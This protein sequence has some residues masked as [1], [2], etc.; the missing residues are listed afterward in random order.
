MIQN[1]N[2]YDIYGYL[3]PGLV[4]LGLVWLPFGLLT[5]DK[6]P[7]EWTSAIVGIA[8]AYIVG[9]VL[10]T[11][12]SSAIRSKIKDSGGVL[13]YPSEVLLDT[14][15]D[16]FTGE[17]KTRLYE[18]IRSS[19]GIDVEGELLEPSDSLSRRRQEVFFLCR[20]EL[21]K[22][23]SVSY[24]E[25]FEGMYT[26]MR[27]I[28]AA[29]AAGSAYYLGWASGGLL[30]SGFGRSSWLPVTVGLT[31]AV[32]A[33]VIA[34]LSLKPDDSL[35]KLKTPWWAAGGV[36]L[37]IF[38]LGNW[39]AAITMTLHQPAIYL[40][41]ALACFLISLRCLGAYKAFALEF[42][43]AVYLGFYDHK[44]SEDKEH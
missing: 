31:F 32:A 39:A 1:F 8:L 34:L 36:L 38:G 18:R 35:A 44:K 9:H 42:P 33:S 21:I 6:L 3:L 16:T 19:F 10:Q 24:A 14:E 37:A 26:L 11:F 7:G 13:R 40:F 41:L 2:F 5:E 43:K 15:N 29:T 20:V 28:V 30:P 17:F 22:A 27:G 23:K 12:A 4:F 25:Q